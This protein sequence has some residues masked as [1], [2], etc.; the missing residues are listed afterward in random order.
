M[1]VEPRELVYLYSRQVEH[2]QLGTCSM[3]VYRVYP[4]TAEPQLVVEYYKNGQLVKVD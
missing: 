4:M 3:E 2:Q 1:N